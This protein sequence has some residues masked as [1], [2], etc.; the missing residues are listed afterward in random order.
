[1]PL[2]EVVV[3]SRVWS[4]KDADRNHWRPLLAQFPGL[5]DSL[6]FFV[7][8][9]CHKAQKCFEAHIRVM[10]DNEIECLQDLPNFTLGVLFKDPGRKYENVPKNVQ[11]VDG[12]DQL[13][14]RLLS[15]SKGK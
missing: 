7:R 8:E 2:T 6:H 1:M 12:W 14:R 4:I 3:V 13:S 9:R 11:S 5:R 15:L 10:V